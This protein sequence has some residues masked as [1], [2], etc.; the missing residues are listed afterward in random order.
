MTYLCVCIGLI[1]LFTSDLL[2]CAFTF[3]SISCQCEARLDCLH[4]VVCSVRAYSIWASSKTNQRFIYARCTLFKWKILWFDYQAQD[5]CLHCK[6]LPFKQQSENQYQI[7]LFFFY[8]C[9]ALRQRENNKKK[10]RVYTERKKKWQHWASNQSWCDLFQLNNTS[11]R[12]GTCCTALIKSGAHDAKIGCE[13]CHCFA[14]ESTIY[15]VYKQ[16]YLTAFEFLITIIYHSISHNLGWSGVH[17]H[18]A[19]ELS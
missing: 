2:G 8:V 7:V 4:F 19:C 13:R 15:C 18:R 6:Q 1:Y 16:R 10:H 5:T 17:R 3:D 12:L 9:V 14:F 11:T